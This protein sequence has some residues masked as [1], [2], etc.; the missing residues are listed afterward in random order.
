MTEQSDAAL[1]RQCQAGDKT[2]FSLLA[3]R[4]WER[5]RRV[6]SAMLSNPD[7]VDDLLQETFLRA[8]LGLD[9]LRQPEQFRAW[10][11]GIGINLARMYLRAPFWRWRSWGDLDALDERVSDQALSPERMVERR[12][13]AVR[14]EQ[15]IADLP[16]SE[17]E[18]LLLVYRDGFS[19]RETA[20]TL[21]ASL[22]AVKVRVHRGRKRLRTVLQPEFGKKY[23]P[24]KRDEAREATMIKVQ[25]HDV[26]AKVSTL[27]LRP[28]LE[29][30]L[31]LLP[32]EL[33]DAFLKSA[34]L[35]APASMELRE[36]ILS[37]PEERQKE[38]HKALSPF[39]PHR[40]VLLKEAEA[41]RILPIWIGP[42][43]ADA[44]VLKL[45]ERPLKRPITHD[46]LTTLLDLGQIQ[47]EQATI[48]RLHEGIF[49]GTLVARLG[50]NGETT[51][52]DCRPSDA[53]SLAV[54]LDTPI[55]VAP[56]VMDEAGKGLDEDG[57]LV[58]KRLA[59]PSDDWRSL[60]K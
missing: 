11:C 34:S 32:E 37:L 42:S 20:V 17:R 27:D 29:P 16:P 46:L 22:S 6:L 58:Y 45:R 2:A 53:L 3:A 14:L 54:R 4:H 8:Y 40:I 19:H 18:A 5:V 41:D 33:Q 12:E 31:A 9:T 28:Y 24:P 21:G 50:Q 60:V 55:Y 48:S 7:D 35:N 26:L 49:Y 52:V 57:R 56:E 59:Y 1:A 43:E 51:E 15:A 30:A 38:L 39:M 36:H 44:I 13:T 47:I 10:T 23:R 25:I